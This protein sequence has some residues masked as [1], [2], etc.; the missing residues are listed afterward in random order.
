MFD[1]KM[2]RADDRHAHPQDRLGEQA[3]GRRRAR[4][5]DVRELDDE[6]VD[7]RERCFGGLGHCRHSAACGLRSAA[8]LRR[9]SAGAWCGAAAVIRARH[10]EQEL[11]HVPRAGRTPLGAQAAVQAHV[12]VLHHHPAGL[13][14]ARHVKILRAVVR[15]HA[16]PRPQLV[17]VAVPG[18]VDA[19]HRAD[20][21]AGVAF[22]AQAVG[23]D[24]LHVA[25]EAALRLGERELRVE[26]ELD[27]DLDVLQRELRLLQGTR[28]RCAGTIALS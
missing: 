13:E 15:G 21:D 18:E 20:V 26:A 8:V 24:G 23:K 16:Q 6:I 27:L 25:V 2:L 10:V 1:G 9:Y 28:K 12:L 5:V 19:V 14:R 11:L 3:V 4:A 7:A 17:L 22:D